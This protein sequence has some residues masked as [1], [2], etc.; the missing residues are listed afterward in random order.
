LKGPFYGLFLASRGATPHSPWYQWQSAKRAQEGFLP[1]HP[2]LFGTFFKR[3]LFQMSLQSHLSFSSLPLVLQHALKG[4]Y[5]IFISLSTYQNSVSAIR[6]IST[7]KAHLNTVHSRR[8]CLR[9]RFFIDS[10]Y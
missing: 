7:Q 1:A 3:P 9:D 4:N 8:R 5:T 2:D 10:S 6:T